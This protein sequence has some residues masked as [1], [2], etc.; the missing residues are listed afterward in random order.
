MTTPTFLYN[1]KSVA[2][3]S[4]AMAKLDSDFN[5]AAVY[6]LAPSKNGHYSCDCPANARAV[7]TKP[8][9]HR[10]MLPIMLGAVN[11]DRF[12]NP[13]NGSWC[14]LLGDLD[15]PQAEPPIDLE[16]APSPIGSTGSGETRAAP[17]TADM[18]VVDVLSIIPSSSPTAPSQA[19]TI[20]R[21]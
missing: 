20:R 11:T 7:I 15:R 3:S 2:P 9:K 1:L 18:A 14:Q 17:I 19:P 21:R 5:I 10:R 16:A 12:Y 13:E 6:N 8:C 4:F